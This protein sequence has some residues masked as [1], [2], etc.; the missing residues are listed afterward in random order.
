MADL[1]LSA[2]ERLAAHLPLTY[3]S[4]DYD[5]WG[6]VRDAAGKVFCVLFYSRDEDTL[7]AHRR[8]K[9]DPAL[10]MAT[11]L[12]AAVNALPA[13]IRRIRDGERREA[14]MV[15]ALHDA[16]KMLCRAH[17]RIHGLPRTTDTLLAR[18]IE[19][20]RAKFKDEYARAALA[21]R[22]DGGT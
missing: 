12:I 11:D 17:A 22:K 15:E 7:A 19:N 13:L 18:E 2:L 10:P 8:D 21:A 4:R 6:Y 16:N 3:R 5:D 14:V 1:D 9:T 20:H